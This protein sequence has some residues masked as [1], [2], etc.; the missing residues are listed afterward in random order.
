M[1]SMMFWMLLVFYDV[2]EELVYYVYIDCVARLFFNKNRL[3][4]GVVRCLIRWY[5]CYVF[6]CS[7]NIEDGVVV[8]DEVFIL[9]CCDYCL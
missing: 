8:V 2:D 6:L 5:C 7:A 1:L 3:T 4:F 9:L